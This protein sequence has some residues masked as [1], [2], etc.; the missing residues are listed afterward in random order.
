MKN[1]NE[2]TTLQESQLELVVSEKTIGSLVTN[3]KAIKAL[4]E[5][6]I[7]QYDIS[8]YSSDDIAKCKQDKAL[9]NKAAK[10]LNDKRI[11]LE[12]EWN[13][14][15][16]EFKTTVKE[17]V[18]L[19]K[20]AATKIDS[21]IKQDDE[22]AKEEKMAEIRKIGEKAGVPEVN[23]KLEKVMN[24]KWLNKSTSLKSIEKELAEK[25]ETINESV[26]TLLTYTDVASAALARYHEDLDLNAAIKFANELQKQKTEQR[27][28]EIVESKQETPE[29]NEPAQ[30]QVPAQVE[31]SKPAESKPVETTSEEDAIDAFND[32]L[33]MPPVVR[34]EPEVF[35]R[36]YVIT[37]T[38]YQ[39][40]DIE[41]YLNSLGVNYTID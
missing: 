23:V 10:A 22:R 35:D 1:E 12:K 4:V 27:A 5:S 31:E 25:V 9:L 8:N 38:R 3:A 26:A 28:T 15:F 2:I 11:A 20:S 7:Q 40:V 16:D 32:A 36:G 39:F 21:I 14:P 34:Q 33:G 37:A 30:E 24:P 6:Q 13:T 19:I 41:K 17:T 29:V 18:D